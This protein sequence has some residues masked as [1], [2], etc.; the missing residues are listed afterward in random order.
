MHAAASNAAR[1]SWDILAKLYPMRSFSY[2]VRDGKG[3]AVCDT[4]I[5][6]DGGGATVCVGTVGEETLPEPTPQAIPGPAPE[7]IK[8]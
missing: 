6:E 5:R 4:E 8:V 2:R 1:M 7:G 3:H